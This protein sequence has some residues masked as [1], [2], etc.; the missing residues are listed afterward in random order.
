MELSDCNDNNTEFFALTGTM[1]GKCVN[2]YD[3]DTVTLVLPVHGVFYK[4]KTRLFGIDTPEIRTKNLDE[5]TQGYISK[6]ILSDLILNKIVKVQCFSFDKYGRLLANIYIDN[7][8]ISV[9]DH[10]ILGGYGVKYTGGKKPKFKS[11]Q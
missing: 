11:T 3:G 6:K 10:L 2:V 8:D 5:K 7:M 1:E 4:F 9:S